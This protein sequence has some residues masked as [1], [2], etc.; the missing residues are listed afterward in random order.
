MSRLRVLVAPDKF[1]GT[2]TAAQAA[3]AIAAGVA[4]VWPDACC[5][6]LPFA[7]G[8][9]GT[10]DAALAAGAALRVT[11]VS[12]PLGDP[13]PARW[14]VL[15]S[16]AII[17]MAEASGLRLVSPG[18]HSAR[19][20]HSHGVGELILAALDEGSGTIVVGIG[21]SATTDGGFGALRALGAVFL[22]GE[23]HPVDDTAGLERVE[24]LDLSRMDRRVADTR[25]VLCSDVTNPLLGEHGAA[26]V[27]APQK[28]ADGDA[29]ARLE[30]GLTR[31]SDVVRRETGIDL[32]TERFGGAGGGIAGGLMAV[33]GAR[34]GNGVDVVADLVGLD[35]HLRD[36]DLVVVGEGSMDAQ[37]L[38]GK[39]PI[40][41]ARRAADLGVPAVAVVGRS[42]LR[43]DELAAYNIGAVGDASVAASSVDEALRDPAR[44]VTSATVAALTGRRYTARGDDLPPPRR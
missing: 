11:T 22:D 4:E 20:A 7:D 14:A 25:I 19:H 37:S 18:P 24:R 35:R 38:M 43:A 32:A 29:V 13:T 26:A 39:A 2:L 31:F 1:K 36:A 41:I 34:P 42:G 27:F 3:A 6:L 12:G 10:V 21:G 44:W 23:G 5:T 33:C 16:T 30:R 40:G 8:G 9:D 15:G 17:E 28:G